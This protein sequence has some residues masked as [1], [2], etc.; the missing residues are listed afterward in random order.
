MRL[1]F[2]TTYGP[3][4]LGGIERIA[5]N[6][7]RGYRRAGCDVRWVTSRIPAT[8]PE[9]EDTVRRVP[10]WNAVEDRVGIPLP[11]WGPSALPALREA[12]GGCD[13]VVV[14]E[15][16]Y[17][18]SALALAVARRANKPALLVQNVGFIPYASRVVS[19]VERLA[20]ATLGRWALRTAGH[21][22]LATPTADRFVRDL[23]AGR[24]WSASTSAM[25]IDT[26][27]FAPAT[28]AERLA[29]RS[30]LGLAAGER[31]A[32]F[33][34]RLVEKKGL[35]V[36]LGVAE[37]LPAVR[38]VVAGDGPLR[39]LLAR[40]PQ[41]VLALG[42]VRLEEMARLYHAADAVLLP[43]QGEGLP[44]FVQEAMACGLGAVVS[45]DEIYA[46]DLLGAAVCRGARRDAGAFAEAL[47]GALDAPP[48]ERA[49]ARAYAVERWG[50][51]A[52]VEHHLAALEALRRGE[53]AVA[54]PPPPR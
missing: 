5:E 46:A 33:A 41:N 44:L 19:A 39:P 21:V 10:T 7:F 17:V 32:L 2:V 23:M 12:I 52:T 15:A 18:T 36:V 1:A 37:R 8:L 25:G 28:P 27:A 35:P 48:D 40:A 3:P 26:D 43:S 24:P 20:W 14:L 9:H 42:P 6:L 49:R 34:C 13:A 45:E 22:V 29:A 4:H 47:A 53:L 38:F 16:L 51:E 54:S 30:S 11:V 31:V 50:L